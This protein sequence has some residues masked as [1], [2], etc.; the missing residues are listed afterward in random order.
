MDI[1]PIAPLRS[2]KFS[3][4]TEIEREFKRLSISEEL[5]A[6]EISEILRLLLWGTLL[7]KS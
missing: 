6:K 4:V 5:L 7:E 3:E 2:R 1:S